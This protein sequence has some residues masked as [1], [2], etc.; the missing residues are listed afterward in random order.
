[1]PGSSFLTETSAWAAASSIATWVSWPQACMTPTV[2]PS[3]VAVALLANGRST[4]SLT[5]SASMSARSAT[6]GPGRP[7][8]ITATTPVL[9]TPVRGSSPN[10]R[11]RSATNFAVST[12]RLPSSGFWWRWRRHSISCLAVRRQR[13]VD[14]RGERRGL[15]RGGRRR[16]TSVASTMNAARAR[17]RRQYASER[18]IMVGLLRTRA[19]GV[20]WGE[21]GCSGILQQPDGRPG[22]APT[23]SDPH[24]GQHPPRPAALVRGLPA[25]AGKT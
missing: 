6:T 4:S 20:G 24:I 3:Q 22:R 25:S 13:G 17:L 19:D 8:S 15:E 11:S 2:F 10:E 1:M 23:G 12:S 9:A 21:A 5:G 14:P 7:P 16:R 18:P